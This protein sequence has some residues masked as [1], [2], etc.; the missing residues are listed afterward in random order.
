MR[1]TRALLVDR[2]GRVRH[3]GLTVKD[4]E[5]QAYLFKAALSELRT[6]LTMLTRNESATM[7]SASTA[8]RR[9]VDALGVRMKEDIANLKHEIQ[10]E[11]ENRKNETKDEM[12]QIDIQIESVLNKSLVSLGELRTTIEE[13]RW[14]NMRKSVAA[15]SAFLILIMVSMELL[16]TKQKK[17]PKRPPPP[18][19]VPVDGESLQYV[20]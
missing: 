8:L 20:T 16:S 19:L 4:L 2:T 18:E 7:R 5:S 11:V 1:A 6:E 12:K 3:E 13:V 9:D 17:E 14:D 15:L 10:M